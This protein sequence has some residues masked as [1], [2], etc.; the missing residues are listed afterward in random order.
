V[1]SDKSCQ[2]INPKCKGP[3]VETYFIYYKDKE[4]NETG[5]ENERIVPETRS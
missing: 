2:Q 1:L 3:E 5:A 4:S